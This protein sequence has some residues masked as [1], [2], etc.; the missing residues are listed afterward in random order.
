MYLA[1]KN[2]QPIS[3]YLLILT[4][5]NG[6]IKQFDMKPYLQT[7]IFNEL[8]DIAMFNTVR[9]SFDSIE[10]DNEADIDPEILYKDSVAIESQI[11]SEP[12]SEYGQI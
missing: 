12:K 2:V 10:W 11:A 6:E 3:N 5:A 1:V 9:V 8:N 4:F 7:G